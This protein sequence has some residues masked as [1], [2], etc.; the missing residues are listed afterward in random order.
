[1]MMMNGVTS[2]CCYYYYYLYSLVL[3]FF[4]FSSNSFVFICYI[5]FRDVL[6]ITRE[7]LNVPNFSCL[8]PPFFLRWF[9]FGGERRNKFE[10]QSTGGVEWFFF[11]NLNRIFWNPALF[12]S[13]L[14]VRYLL[15]VVHPHAAQVVNPLG[16]KE[17]K[18]KRTQNFSAWMVKESNGS[19]F[20]FLSV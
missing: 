10:S 12:F 15:G 19:I 4:F 20:L 2:P 5:L 8:L 14:P 6:E 9:F 11:K 17:R 3:L 1:M 7:Q 18:L 16:K 13:P